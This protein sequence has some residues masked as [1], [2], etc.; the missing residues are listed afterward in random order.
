MVDERRFEEF[1]EELEDLM[2]KT[3]EDLEKSI[4][5]LLKSDYTKSFYKPKLYGFSIQLDENGLP[6]ITKFG[7]SL[8]SPS[9]ERTPFY[10]QYIDKSRGQLTIIFEVPGVEKDDI[11]LKSSSTKLILD[12]KSEDRKYH[13]EVDLEAEVDPSTAS[14]SFKNGIL[15]VVFKTKSKGDEFTNLSIS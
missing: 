15:T 5:S 14:C 13:A 2:E 3:I 11:Q 10:D 7:D 6:K 1:F 8:I 12:A 4:R 9:E